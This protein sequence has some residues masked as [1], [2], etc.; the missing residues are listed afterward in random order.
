MIGSS[1]S[2]RAFTSYNYSL[3]SHLVSDRETKRVTRDCS[4]RQR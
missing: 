2:S 4:W 1:E 3:F